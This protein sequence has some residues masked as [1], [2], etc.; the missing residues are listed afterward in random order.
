MV[1]TDPLR[2]SP[3]A[4]TPEP[5]AVWQALTI[6]SGSAVAIVDEDGL[7]RYGNAAFDRMLGLDAGSATGR[8]MSEVLPAAIA[9]ERLAVVRDVAARTHA[10]TI[11][12]MINAAW[13]H[14]TVRP[15]GSGPD[16]KSTVLIVCTQG[17]EVGTHSEDGT[18]FPTAQTHDLGSLTTLTTRELEILK[19]IAMGHSTADI[20]KQLHRSV[21]TIEW[22]RVAL[23]NKLGVTNRVELAHI[24][25][26]AGLVRLDK[27]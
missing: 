26:R 9:E 13:R 18:P 17:A 7:V 8:L 1:I 5:A 6:D 27:A 4:Q 16:G 23:G 12:G 3:P 20:A 21:K 22:H 2:G 19:L 24:A 15:L 25:I 10:R 14:T 11:Q